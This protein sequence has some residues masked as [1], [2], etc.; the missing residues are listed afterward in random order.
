M[1]KMMLA[2]HATG[3]QVKRLMDDVTDVFRHLA[4]P[5]G[6]VMPRSLPDS[7]RTRARKAELEQLIMK[8]AKVREPKWWELEAKGVKAREARKI[9]SH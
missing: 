3:E 1:K 9:L 2:G 7:A 4:A 6:G 5:H 8:E